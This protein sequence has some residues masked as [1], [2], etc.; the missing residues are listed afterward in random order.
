MIVIQ[1]QYVYMKSNS[2]DIIFFPGIEMVFIDNN[3]NNNNNSQFTQ[4][5]SFS[6]SLSVLHVYL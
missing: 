3:Y 5:C 6:L 2:I 4:F 1:F